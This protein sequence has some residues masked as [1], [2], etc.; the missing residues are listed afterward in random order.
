MKLKR[1]LLAFLT[2]LCWITLAWADQTSNVMTVGAG[3]EK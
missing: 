1:V 2:V 3:D